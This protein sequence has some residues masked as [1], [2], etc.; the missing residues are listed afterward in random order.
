MN[1]RIAYMQPFTIHKLQFFLNLQTRMKW[2]LDSLNYKITT[3]VF[4]PEMPVF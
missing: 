2:I 1:S 4:T 3:S